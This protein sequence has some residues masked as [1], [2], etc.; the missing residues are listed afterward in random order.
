MCAC[1]PTLVGQSFR[2]RIHLTDGHLQWP[3]V[4][5]VFKSIMP[6]TLGSNGG[7]KAYTPKVSAYSGRGD[8]DRSSKRCSQSWNK[9]TNVSKYDSSDI[10]E[11][12]TQYHDRYEGS[13]E[14]PLNKIK[15]QSDFTLAEEQ[16]GWNLSQT[17]THGIAVAR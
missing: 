14:V 8:P 15:K 17:M 12:A 5:I 10:T 2:S 7:S 6:S 4:R 3:L 11:V 13:D 1:L 16:R 9:L